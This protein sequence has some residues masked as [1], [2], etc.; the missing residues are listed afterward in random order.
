MARHVAAKCVCCGGPYW[1]SK[2]KGCG[3]C[4]KPDRKCGK[5]GRCVMHCYDRE[6]E[7]EEVKMGRPKGV[8]DE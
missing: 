8:K 6:P 2:R 5:C 3:V 1:S 4:Y 7:F